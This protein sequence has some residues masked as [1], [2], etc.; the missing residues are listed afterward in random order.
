MILAKPAQLALPGSMATLMGTSP[1]AK[2]LSCSGDLK[3]PCMTHVQNGC[4][5]YV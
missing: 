2:I 3:K 5:T 1:Q 4:I